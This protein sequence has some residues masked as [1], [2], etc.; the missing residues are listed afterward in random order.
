MPNSP[1][2]M[3]FDRLRDRLLEAGIAPRHV[4]RYLAELRDHLDDLAAASGDRYAGLMRLGTVDELAQAALA[5]PELQSWIARAPWAVFLV[6]PPV[7]FAG[8]F[9][10]AM[11][12]FLALLSPY[13]GNSASVPDGTRAFIDAV[14][15][16]VV[17]GGPVL[18]GWLLAF[19]ALR[20][21]VSQPLILSGLILIALL[22]GAAEFSVLYGSVPGE[23][24][25]ME[26]GLALLAPYAR[27]P[28]HSIQTAINLALTVLPYLYWRRREHWAA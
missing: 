1:E 2:S 27:L 17:Y 13:E 18:I 10:V 7:L 19:T 3:L 20:H 25:E 16:L 6:A 28:Q 26:I 5:R 24:G 11:L 9:V 8:L 21:R 23:K 15:R 22:G 14:T 4:G 12:G